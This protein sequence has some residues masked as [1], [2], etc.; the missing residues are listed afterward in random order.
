MTRS[1]PTRA[2]PRQVRPREAVDPGAVRVAV[3][4][5]VGSFPTILG[6]T[7]VTVALHDLG[8][9]LGVVVDAVSWVAAAYLL[10]LCAAIPLVGWLQGLLGPRRLW[11]GALVVFLL[12]S[13]LCGSALGFRTLV[14]ARVVQ[15]LGAG[16]MMPLLTTIL[17][18]ATVPRDRPRITS[19]VAVSAALGPILGPTVGGLVL[20]VADWRWLFWMNLPLALLGILLAWRLIPPDGP[21]RRTRLDAVGLFLLVP[22]L[23]GLLWGLPGLAGRTTQVGA[24]VPVVAG[25]ALLAAFVGWARHRGARALLDLRVLRARSLSSASAVLLLSGAVVHGAM[26]LLPLYWQ[27]VRAADPLEAGLHLVPQG[28]G[29]LLSRVAALRLMDRRGPRVVAVV[30]FATTAL[31]TLPFALLD[32]G[33]PAW[34][35]VAALLARGIGIGMVVVPLMSVAFEAVEHEDVPHASVVVRVSQQVGGSAG[36]ALLAVVLTSVTA[37]SGS[38]AAGF[39]TAFWCA[40]AVAGLAALLSWVLPRTVVS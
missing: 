37:S 2:A 39:A 33:A 24:W 1:L 15:G 8:A 19:L 22:A 26:L 7:T 14:A 29:S 23:V 13:L 27:Q 40:T 6:T 36:V 35:L 30:G 3:A 20:A 9:D 34:L 18:R 17:V 38:T 11:I 21:E 12:G 4:V 28:V 10:A 31:A 16:V 5:L 32:D 25:A